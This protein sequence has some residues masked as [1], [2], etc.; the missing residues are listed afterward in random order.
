VKVLAALEAIDGTIPRRR[1]AEGN[2]NNGRRR[3]EISVGRE[4]SPVIYIEFYEWR[5]DEHL[6]DEQLQ[7]IVQL[8]RAIGRADES[9]FETYQT[10]LGGRKVT[11]RFW[12]D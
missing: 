5:E 9:Q 7:A 4:G 3:Y 11:F 10:P 2:P 8:M 6:P 1:Y 12:W